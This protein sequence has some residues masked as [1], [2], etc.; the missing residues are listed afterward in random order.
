MSDG[1]FTFISRDDVS[2]VY[3]AVQDYLIERRS[4]KRLPRDSDRFNLMLGE[5]NRLPYSKLGQVRGLS[6]LVN[7]YRGS[8]VICRK[9][10]MIKTL[11]Q[12]CTTS[13]VPLF[14]WLPVS[15]IIY[16]KSRECQVSTSIP[17]TR[18][19][20]LD[21]RNELLGIDKS[22][23]SSGKDVIWISKIT[24][25]S[26]GEGINISRD[27]DE[28]LNEIDSQKSAYVIQ[29]YID[30]PLL[31]E[32]GRK[33]DIR[34]WVLLDAE[35]SIYLYREGV[36]RTASELYSLDHL[37][38]VTAHLTNHNLQEERSPNFGK[39]EDG[40]EMF[41]D[42]FDRYLQ[43]KYN[44]TMET[45]LLPQIKQVIKSCLGIIKEQINT[46][47]L[48]YK[49]F[50]LFGFDFMVDENFKVWL[51]EINGGPAC[52][53]RL[54]PDLVRCLVKTAVDPIFPTDPSEQDEDNLFEKI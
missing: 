5:R 13:N 49:C 25:G 24:A 31:L 11:K 12:Y 46:D 33:F 41:Y 50:Q 38:D 40:N 20:Q 6:Q 52:A 48:D 26:K 37:G 18:P 19:P 9:V 15:Y 45:T 30:P 4:W 39:Y 53:Q 29:Q 32:G 10:L 35:Y 3:K 21:E 44:I 36:L 7:Y 34:C 2:S 42:Q 28:L 51:L 22:F 23:K 27:V 1:Q 14:E 17:V 54:L 16:P 8:S 47:G 43:D